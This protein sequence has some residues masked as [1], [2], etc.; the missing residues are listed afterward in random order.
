[1]RAHRISV[2]HAGQIVADM[3]GLLAVVEAR[4]V[5][6]PEVALHQLRVGHIGIEE[7]CD[8]LGGSGT[9]AHDIGVAIDAAEQQLLDRLIGLGH[10]VREGGDRHRGRSDILDT[11]W[12]DLLQPVLRDANHILHHARDLPAHDL[13]GE[14]V[15]IEM[16][17]TVAHLLHQPGEEGHVFQHLE[18][19]IARAQ[20]VINVMGVVSDVIGNGRDLG[21]QA[22]KARQFQ[23]MDLAIVEDRLRNGSTC[24]LPALGFQRSI[25]LHKTFERLP[26]QVQSVEIGI[27]PFELGHDTQRLGIVVEAAIGR[28]HLVQR[29]FTRMAKRRVAEVVHQRHAFREILVELQSTRQRAGNLR[30]L[31]RVCQTGT[32]VVTIRADEDLGLVLEA[33]KGG[34]VNDAV[35]V[36]LEFGTRQAAA[37]GKEAAAALPGIGGE[38]RPL[39]GAETQC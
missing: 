20:A 1:M 24:P 27:T 36:A 7:V 9:D 28:E 16:G 25:M 8:D 15:S 12:L 38:N 10:L 23:V 39:A 37:L 4:D 35:A 31:D 26:G 18:G 2:G 21:F 17:I 14:P 6:D 33:S 13:V 5:V 30:H 32:I 11:L 3:A 34:G 22:G 19:E 29:I